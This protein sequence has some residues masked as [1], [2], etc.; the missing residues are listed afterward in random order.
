MLNTHARSERTE[1][2]SSGTVIALPNSALCRGKR[3]G[4][5]NMVYCLAPDPGKCEYAENFAFNVYCYHPNRAQIAAR[6]E[7]EKCE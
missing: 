3:S 1:Q 4:I 5:A 6:T 2:L 7:N